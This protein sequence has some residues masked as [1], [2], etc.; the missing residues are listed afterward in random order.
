MKLFL[1]IVKNVL[2]DSEM[3]HETGYYGQL[4]ELS[5]VCKEWADTIRNAPEL[6]TQVNLSGSEEHIEVLISRSGD[7]L[8][9]IEGYLESSS[10]VRMIKSEAHR[11]RTLEIQFDDENLMTS[12]LSKPAPYLKELN[13]KGPRDWVPQSN[14]FE[15]AVPRLEAVTVR[16]CGLPWRSPSLSDLRKLT[17][18]GIEK[19]APQINDLLKI[20]SASPRLNELGITLT[21]IQL[22]RYNPSRRVQLPN[23]RSLD[24]KY[25]YPEIMTAVLNSIDAPLS[26]ACVLCTRPD[27]EQ[28]MAVELADVSNRLVALAQSARSGFGTLTLQMGYEDMGDWLDVEEWDAEFKY[29]PEGDHLGPLSITVNASP[30]RHVDILSHLAGKV[31]PYTEI[32]PPKLR[33]VDIHRT[34]PEDE[35][36]N[37][38]CGLHRTF[39]NVRDIALI[40]LDYEATV[41]ALQRL[42]PRPGSG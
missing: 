32:S 4:T 33:L 6:W 10:V 1:L 9:D 22:D 27:D 42:F 26:A 36:A 15:G 3:E 7:F 8:L 30:E 39:P 24:V 13:I 23:L 31:Q 12:L 14:I 35:D 17:L 25:L 11:W 21:H 40:D 18:S 28:D 37:L 29:E 16:S 2:A 5:L 34:V 19:H 38:L 20:L 41:D